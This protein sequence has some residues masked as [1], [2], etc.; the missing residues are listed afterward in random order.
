GQDPI[1]RIRRRGSVRRLVRRGGRDGGARGAPRQRAAV[2]ILLWGIAE[3]RPLAA[4]RAA[5]AAMGREAFVLD[6]RA[7]LELS[8]EL[9]VG[10]DV[11][12]RIVGPSRSIDLSRVSAVYARPYDPTA[13]PTIARRGRG[14]AAFRHAVELHQAF[15]A[16]TEVTPA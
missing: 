11:T 8:L 4:V 10:K 15:R 12:G 14:S 3:E 13:I 5:L 1:A 16:W 6:Q 9:T 2:M 7:S